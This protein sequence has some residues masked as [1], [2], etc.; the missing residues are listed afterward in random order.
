M[1]NFA[2]DGQLNQRE[3]G[4]FIFKWKSLKCLFK[5]IRQRICK[6]TVIITRCLVGINP[7]ILG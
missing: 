1:K 3:R 4:E 7:V 6:F 5:V 2:A